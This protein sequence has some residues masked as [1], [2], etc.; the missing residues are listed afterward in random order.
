MGTMP[1]KERKRLDG[2]VLQIEDTLKAA[3]E[4]DREHLEGGILLDYEHSSEFCDID[5]E[6]G[7]TLVIR[8]KSRPGKKKRK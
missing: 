4:A 1:K 2:V 7:I 3:I 8:I 6:A 5:N